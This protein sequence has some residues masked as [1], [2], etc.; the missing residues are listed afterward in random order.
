MSYICFANKTKYV[1]TINFEL[2]AI[3]HRSIRSFVNLKD[4]EI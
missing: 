2:N 1:G 3:S 4:L